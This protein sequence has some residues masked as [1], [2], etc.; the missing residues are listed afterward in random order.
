[1]RISVEKDGENIFIHCDEMISSQE[2]VTMLE[3]AAREFAAESTEH[4]FPVLSLHTVAKM[5]HAELDHAM[6]NGRVDQFSGPSVLAAYERL[7]GPE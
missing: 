7:V 3:R 4:G 1:M 5:L 2:V 6:R